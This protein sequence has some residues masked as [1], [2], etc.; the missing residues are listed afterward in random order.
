MSI[1]FKLAST[2][3]HPTP[4]ITRTRGPSN[5]PFPN[6]TINGPMGSARTTSSS[7]YR[8]LLIRS[9]RV[10][11]WWVASL[12]IRVASYHFMKPPRH[13]VTFLTKVKCSGFPLKMSSVVFHI[14]TVLNVSYFKK[15]FFFSCF[16]CIL[17]WYSADPD[18]SK[19]GGG[20]SVE[21]CGLGIF[22]SLFTFC[23]PLIR[24]NVRFVNKNFPGELQFW[25]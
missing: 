8:K 19:R 21:F 14:S 9:L 24:L 3:T 22:W 6:W 13:V 15:V 10:S 17:Y 16:R 23:R 4:S 25:S 1:Y 18:I 7:F 11:R 2:P 5:P 20:G 12:I